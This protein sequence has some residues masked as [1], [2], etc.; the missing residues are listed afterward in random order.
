MASSLRHMKQDVQYSYR[1][2]EALVWK[3]APELL[4]QG[5]GAKQRDSVLSALKDA[6]PASVCRTVLFTS[7]GPVLYYRFPVRPTPEGR[8]TT[9]SAQHKYTHFLLFDLHTPS[10]LFTLTHTLATQ[11]LHQSNTSD[12]S[13]AL[14]TL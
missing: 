9:R 11:L 12:E 4:V 1:D 8:L 3:I 10:T 6:T 13:S 7:P 14:R 2:E 5:F